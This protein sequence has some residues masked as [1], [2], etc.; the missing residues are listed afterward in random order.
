SSEWTSPF[1]RAP[2]P[3]TRACSRGR[4]FFSRRFFVAG[5]E[6]SRMNVWQCLHLNETLTA[7]VISDRNRFLV[8]L[9]EPPEEHRRPMEFYRWT[10]NDAKRAAD[11][12]VQVYYPHECSDS[13]CGRWR[14]L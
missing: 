7:I 8:R 2:A 4:S 14:K 5:S 3:P 12:L 6:G 13:K 1:V 10:L 9:R 11:R